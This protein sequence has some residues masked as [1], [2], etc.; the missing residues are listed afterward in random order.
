[1]KSRKC[2]RNYRYKTEDKD[3]NYNPMNIDD[4][5]FI[6]Q[7]LNYLNKVKQDLKKGIIRGKVV[8]TT[9]QYLI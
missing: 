3:D 9:K 6:R 1:M 4:P 8:G 2:K 7:S 5:E